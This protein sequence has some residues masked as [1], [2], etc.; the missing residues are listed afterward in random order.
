MIVNSIQ[1][2]L[3][4]N[5]FSPIINDVYVTPDMMYCNWKEAAEEYKKSDS[6]DDLMLAEPYSVA[7]HF[8]NAW[9]RL[10]GAKETNIVYRFYSPYMKYVSF[11]I[12]P[13]L[14]IDWKYNN[15][16]LIFAGGRHM[17]YVPVAGRVVA[18]CDVT[19][20]DKV[21]LMSGKI[22][23]YSLLELALTDFMIFNNNDGYNPGQFM[24]CRESVWEYSRNYE[25]CVAP[26]NNVFPVM[27]GGKLYGNG[28][29]KYINVA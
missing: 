27:Y 26:V 22:K 1:V 2:A 13:N 23:D 11:Y 12:D 10:N 14:T 25:N 18:L 6:K 9:N 3:I 8:I 15:R 16:K 24:A 4:D 17:K 29:C 21:Y 28:E 20:D 19:I 7:L 5:G